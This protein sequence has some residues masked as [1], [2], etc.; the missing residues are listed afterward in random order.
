MEC[1]DEEIKEIIESVKN[2][3]VKMCEE[4]WYIDFIL[5]QV[6]DDIPEKYRRPSN[7]PVVRAMIRDRIDETRE[8]FMKEVGLIGDEDEDDEEEI[9]DYIINIDITDEVAGTVHGVQGGGPGYRD[10]V[11][12]LEE[13]AGSV[14]FYEHRDKGL[15]GEINTFNVDIKIYK[16]E[17]LIG[18]WGCPGALHMGVIDV[19]RDARYEMARIYNEDMEEKEEKGT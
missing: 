17:D 2:T 16:N 14:I 4:E 6:W 1:T 15:D 11:R 19:L 12:E 3:P 10:V 5:E 8:G 7:I 13:A 9:I 18:R